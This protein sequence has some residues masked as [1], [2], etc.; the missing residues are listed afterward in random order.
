MRT[1][2]Y[3]PARRG[4]SRLKFLKNR[5]PGL[6]VY[7]RDR[8]TGGLRSVRRRAL[9]YV[10]RD[11]TS[12]QKCR[13]VSIL[14]GNIYGYLHDNLTSRGTNCDVEEVIYI[15]FSFIYLF[16]NNG[17]VISVEYFHTYIYVK[18]FIHIYIYH[19]I[20]SIC[21]HCQNFRVEMC[22]DPK[23]PEVTGTNVYIR[24]TSRCAR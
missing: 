12:R 14:Y 16:H 3:I 24:R 21:I 4:S 9:V 18:R 22:I 5:H 10:A 23:S 13:T 8:S 2:A 1:R 17:K 20:M 19:V 6:G 11:I 15:S 7:L